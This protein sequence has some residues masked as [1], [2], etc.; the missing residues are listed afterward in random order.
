MTIIVFDHG[1]IVA[2]GPHP[3]LYATNPLYRSLYDRQQGVT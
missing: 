1:N 2:T 3:H